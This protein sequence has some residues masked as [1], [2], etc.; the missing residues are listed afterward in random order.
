MPKIVADTY[1]KNILIIAKSIL[2]LTNSKIKWYPYRG[3]YT[4]G[5]SGCIHMSLYHVFLETG[6]HIRSKHMLA[7]LSL[8]LNV[9]EVIVSY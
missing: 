4:Q 1:I 8:C 6:G 7:R 9:L 5:T 3:T 2:S